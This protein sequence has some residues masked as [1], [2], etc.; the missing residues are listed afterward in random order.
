MEKKTAQELADIIAAQLGSGLE[1]FHAQLLS[2]AELEANRTAVKKNSSRFAGLQP[3][4]LAYSSL[5]NQRLPGAAIL[6]FA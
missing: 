1:S 2:S 5:Q 6:T 3:A 4:A